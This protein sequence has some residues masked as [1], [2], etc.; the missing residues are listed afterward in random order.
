MTV[1]VVVGAGPEDEKP[2]PPASRP[3][4]NESLMAANSSAVA[5]RVAASSPI[6]ARRMAL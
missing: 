1:V 5:T 4:R 6:T 2:M 3:W